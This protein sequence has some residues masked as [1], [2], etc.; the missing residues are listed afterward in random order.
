MNPGETGLRESYETSEAN[1][2]AGKNLMEKSQGEMDK[3]KNEAQFVGDTI[4]EMVNQK[5]ETL[6]NDMEAAKDAVL[7]ADRLEKNEIA[8]IREIDLSEVTSF[9]ELYSK[10]INN[11]GLPASFGVENA[12]YWVKTIE[13]VRSGKAAINTMT[14]K[15]GLRAKVQELLGNNDKAEVYSEKPEE[16]LAAIEAVRAE[17][18]PS[19]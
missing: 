1:F 18:S 4:N 9:S 5:A 10:I 6:D 3:L 12:D 13:D 8:K 17:H 7:G 14:S 16:D 11:G 19:E 15:S 2:T